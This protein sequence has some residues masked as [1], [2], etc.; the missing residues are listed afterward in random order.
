METIKKSVK[1]LITITKKLHK[2]YPS[3][4]FTLD[5]RLVGDI[6]EIAAEKTYDIKLFDK[7]QKHYDA[8][9][10][11]DKNKKVQIKTTMKHSLIF[12]TNNI[13]QYY[14]GLKINEDGNIET[15]FNGLASIIKKYLDK[16]RKKTKSGLY[17]ISNKKLVELNNQVKEKDRLPERKNSYVA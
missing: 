5:G 11:R 17:S 2:E 14:L 16:N 10:L 13:P 8:I 1:E 9:L 6:G 7:Q 3:K 4:K 12:P 15:I